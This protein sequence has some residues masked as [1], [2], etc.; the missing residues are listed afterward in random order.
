MSPL[1]PLSVLGGLMLFMS[2]DRTLEGAASLGKY[3]F[4]IMSMQFPSP[5]AEF[6]KV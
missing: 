3:G 6:G 1:M 4:F 5:Q 2:L